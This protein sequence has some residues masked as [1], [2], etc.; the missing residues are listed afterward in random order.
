MNGVQD[1]DR[2]W[3]QLQKEIAKFE[4]SYIKAGVL[5]DAGDYPGGVNLASVATFHEFGTSRMVARPFMR[6][7]YDK[8]QE[9]VKRFLDAQ[10]DSVLTGQQTAIRALRTLGVFY[11]GA[12]QNELGSGDFAPTKA[13]TNLRKNMKNASFR[14][15]VASAKDTIRVTHR[16]AAH[17]R[18]FGL[19]TS[20]RLRL[21]SY[22]EK[23]EASRQGVDKLKGKRLEARNRK[24]ARLEGHASKLRGKTE[25]RVKK[26]YANK[27]F[28]QASEF[29]KSGGK[30]TPLIDTGRLRQSIDFEVVMG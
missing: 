19:K 25:E 26:I 8:N 2:G 9:V 21:F 11:K 17:R 5:S 20:E 24:I 18:K 6:Q 14:M 30:S 23:L 12:I 27:R 15:K 22:D 29:L 28:Q 1:I 16:K 10:Y 4:N 7:T 3:K 13:S